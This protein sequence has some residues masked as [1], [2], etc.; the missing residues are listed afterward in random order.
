VLLLLLVLG[1]QCAGVAGCTNLKVD[2]YGMDAALM[3]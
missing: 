1:C 2:P 3:P